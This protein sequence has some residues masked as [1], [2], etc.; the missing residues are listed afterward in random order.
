MKRV[1]LHSDLNNCYATIE[2]LHRPELRGRPFAVGGNVESRHG[3]ILSKDGLAKKAGVKTGEAI[4]QAKLKCP[5]LI[6]VPPDFDLYWRFCRRVR[7]I[8]CEYTDRVQPFGLDE[9]WLDLTGTEGLNAGGHAVADELRS[10]V[11]EE[12]GLSVSVGVSFNKIFAKLGSDYRKPDATTVISQAN[13]KDIVWPLPAGDLLYVGPATQKKLARYGIHTIGDLANTAPDGL[14]R[15]LGVMGLTLHAFANG[16]DTS[17]VL[18]Q[19][20]EAAVK[21]IGN[22]I[23]AQRDIL[24]LEDARIVITGLSESVATRLRQAG[25]QAT[26]VVLSIRDSSLGSYERQRRL[27]VPTDQAKELI[28]VAMALL[29]ESYR[30]TIPIRSLGV[31]GT[32]LCD[33]NGVALQVSMFRDDAVREKNRRVEEAMDL[34][35][36]RFGHNAIHRA[37]MLADETLGGFDASSHTIH[38]VSYF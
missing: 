11:K 18:K 16:H 24:T 17:P 20:E 19:G 6:T 1:V 30:W 25:L 35:R 33:L 38:P 34:V 2:L 31:R 12:L 9:C 8:Y 27:D 21:S 15:I 26:C 29:E 32:G 5:G 7:A 22:G 37:I 3:I 13:Y 36:R 4:W 14:Q 28:D 10:R 23:T